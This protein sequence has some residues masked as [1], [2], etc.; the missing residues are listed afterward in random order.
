VADAPTT[1]V[2][3]PGGT[4]DPGRRVAHGL[5]RPL[6]EIGDDFDWITR[7]YDGFRLFMMEELAARVPERQRWTPADLETVLVEALASALDQLSDRAD[8]VAAEAYLPTARRPESVR[9]LLQYIGYD[10]VHV[11]LATGDIKPDPNRDSAAVL[12]A[13]WL[14]NPPMMEA[15][16][17]AGV[18]AIH[19]QNR[20][21]TAEDHGSQ[22]ELHPAVQRA[23]G[24][25]EWGGAWSVVRVG[26][27]PVVDRPIDEK[28]SAD[29]RASLQAAVDAFHVG[30]DVPPVVWNADTTTRS[31][32]TPYIE[33]L[34]MVGQPVL[35]EDAV[36][37]G[38]MMALSV[39]V[40]DNHFQSE[41]RDA[42]DRA[43][44]TGHDG[45]FAPERIK[46]GDVLHLSDVVQTLMAVDGVA[47]ASVNRF[48]R[49]GQRWP[50][51]VVAGRIVLHGIE[52][53]SC[54]NDHARPERGYYIL[55]LHGGRIG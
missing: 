17:A 30:R 14:A 41:V 42:I 33:R 23:G 12:D 53:A 5:P 49:V 31:V 44:G 21:V 45:F 40:R 27:L 54:D 19:D 2:V 16:R 48:K 55:V 43:L 10:A 46:F 7:D 34:R 39:R 15:A 11:A 13:A 8:R 29:D 35:L 3:F 52:F 20:M 9:R 47:V 18:R 37:V 1:E 36:R 38:I 32:L 28:W 24:V 26:V 4:P 22:L 6:P 50:D 25:A 51:Q